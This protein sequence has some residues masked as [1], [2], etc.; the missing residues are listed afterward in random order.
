[1]YKNKQ[2]SLKAEYGLLR[3]IEDERAREDILDNIY[4]Q[5]QAGARFDG[6]MDVYFDVGLAAYHRNDF[7]GALAPLKTYTDASPADTDK[8]TEALYY[9][10][11]SFLSLNEKKQGFSYMQQVADSAADSVYKTMAKSELASDE[12]KKSLSN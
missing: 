7:S 1:M 10:G 9:L 4:K 8:K 6:Y 12:W 11:K 3:E 5:V 2:V